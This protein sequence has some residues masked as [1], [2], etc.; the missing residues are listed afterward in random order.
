MDRVQRLARLVRHLRGELFEAEWE[1]GRHVLRGAGAVQAAIRHARQRQHPHRAQGKDAEEGR[2]RARG[3][4]R[5]PG[6]VRGALRAT[7]RATAQPA[8]LVRGAAQ[9]AAQGCARARRDGPVAGTGQSRGRSDERA[10]ASAARHAHPVLV[11]RGVRGVRREHAVPR[12]RGE[13][14][15]ELAGRRAKV[16]VQGCVSQHI[17]GDGLHLVPEMQAPREA[18][19]P[20][21]GHRAQGIAPPG[22]PARHRAVAIGSRRPR[23]HGGQVFPRHPRRP[24]TRGGALPGPDASPI[25]DG[26]RPGPILRGHR[27]EQGLDAGDDEKFDGRGDQ[28]RRRARLR[29]RDRRRGRGCP[30]GR[31]R[32]RGPEGAHTRQALR[33]RGPV[34]VCATRA[35]GGAI[36]PVRRVLVASR[37]VA[38]CV[39]VV[40]VVRG[41]CCRGG[42]RP[43]GSHRR[44]HRARPRRPGDAGGEGR[45]RG[46]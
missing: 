36:R 9:G 40:V 34:Q 16:P 24:R 27:D 38:S 3:L 37:G 39:V 28:R 25:R 18:A 22:A 35:A 42:R 30:R 1:R 23:Q 5:G 15:G 21:A 6:E 33:R 31:R 7:P 10:D 8:L 20:R 43:R 46:G 11:Q 44:A 29:R 2:G 12:W 17:R 26:S 45:V 14:G 19:A 41:G 4:V 13:R 32:R